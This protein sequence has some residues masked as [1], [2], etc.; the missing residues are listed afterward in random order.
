LREAALTAQQPVSYS[1]DIGVLFPS[2]PGDAL[3]VMRFD[4]AH[5]RISAVKV[6]YLPASLAKATQYA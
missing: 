4:A 5:Q 2:P 3:R 1:L 6:G